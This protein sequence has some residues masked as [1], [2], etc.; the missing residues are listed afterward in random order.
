M[1]VAERSRGEGFALLDFRRRFLF[2][3]FSTNS[4]RDLNKVEQEP[5]PTPEQRSAWSLQQS[6]D[7]VSGTFCQLVKVECYRFY[8]LIG[9]RSAQGTLRESYIKHQGG[10]CRLTPISCTSSALRCV[11]ES[12]ERYSEHLPLSKLLC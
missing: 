5:G 4:G 2:G 6:A 1:Y 3:K 8:V 7:W 10:K 12:T 9:G 11:A